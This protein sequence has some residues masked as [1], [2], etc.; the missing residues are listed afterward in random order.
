[1]VFSLFALTS[2]TTKPG[3]RLLHVIFSMLLFAMCNSF[4]DRIELVLQDTHE[5]IES[6]YNKSTIS[7]NEYLSGRNL[8]WFP[9]RKRMIKFVKFEKEIGISL[10]RLYA[11]SRDRNDFIFDRDSKAL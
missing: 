2:N 9:F 4:K 7:C 3:G 1:M 10:S 5:T 11:K 6:K 8:S